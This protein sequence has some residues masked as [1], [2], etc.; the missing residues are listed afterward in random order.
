MV[1]KDA[2][3]LGTGSSGKGIQGREMGSAAMHGHCVWAEGSDTH[4]CRVLG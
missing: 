3:L 4:G 1:G 2:F